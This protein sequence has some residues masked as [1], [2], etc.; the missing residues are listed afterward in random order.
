[1]EDSL[2][3]RIIE[4]GEVKNKGTIE[5][6]FCEKEILSGKSLFPSGKYRHRCFSFY[7]L[8]QN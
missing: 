3:C 6:Q 4:F 7:T 8:I 5:R 2:K 1:M